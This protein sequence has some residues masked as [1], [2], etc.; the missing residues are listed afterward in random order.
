MID[1]IEF[2]NQLDIPQESILSL[3]RAAEWSSANKPDQLHR[4]LTNS[5]SIVTAWQADQL[6][7]LANA[8]S[9]G[10]LVVYYP[11]VVVH[12]DLQGRG[13]G[14][15]MM[16]RLMER[17]KDFHQ[18]SILADKDAVGFFERCGFYRS[19]CPAMWIYDGSD[20]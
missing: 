15:E 6:V 5:D 20:H 17:Y 13:I 4:G 2:D 9:D 8:I 16:R 18:H 3:Y 1:G 10:H 7:G 19:V 12:P 14:K 11:H